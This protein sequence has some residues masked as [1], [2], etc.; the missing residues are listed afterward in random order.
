[1]LD[2][3]KDDVDRRSELMG[4]AREFG[5]LARRSRELLE[6]DEIAFEHMRNGAWMDLSE[7]L[8]LRARMH[9]LR[10]DYRALLN[11]AGAVVIS[12]YKTKKL[13]IADLA[14]LSAAK[15]LNEY[16]ALCAS[17][18][19]VFSLLVGGK[20][21]E[22]SDA[23]GRFFNYEVCGNSLQLDDGLPDESGEDKGRLP[24]REHHLSLGG[25]S[26]DDD[27]PPPVAQ[28]ERYAMACR[29]LSGMVPGGIPQTALIAFEQ[30][31]HA[32]RLL[33][34]DACTDRAAYEALAESSGTREFAERWRQLPKHETWTRN[35]RTYRKETN[36]QKNRPRASRCVGGKSIVREDEI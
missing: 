1:M 21:V 34:D 6:E 19:N 36:T 18:A 20:C 13:E 15:D 8:P 28:C 7:S 10:L 25:K 22:L 24:M 2:Q 16:G 9:E 17:D 35:L 12:A 31:E 23:Q 29:K 30:Y 26:D 5:S 4:L 14:K 33:G 32:K 3:F 11:Q 27:W